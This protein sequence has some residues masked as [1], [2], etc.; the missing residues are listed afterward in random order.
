MKKIVVFC[1]VFMS[2]GFTNLFAQY[3]LS[4]LHSLSGKKWVQKVNPD[5]SK[6]NAKQL[7]A[8]FTFFSD[9]TVTAEFGANPSF[10]GGGTPSRQTWTYGSPVLHWTVIENGV[11]QNY[12]AEIQVLTADKL[13]VSLTEPGREDS[14]S[15]LFVATR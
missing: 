15:V 11:V 4:L 3:D 14:R 1:V 5:E 10:N 6:A 13:V 8:S 9:G 2:V 7:S 12:R